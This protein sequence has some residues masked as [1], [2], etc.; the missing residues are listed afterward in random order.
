MN[1]VKESDEV[2]VVNAVFLD[3]DGVI[4][5]DFGYVGNWADFYF[6]PGALDALKMLSD[7][8]VDIF[9]VTNQSG[10][11]RG[12]YT[13]QEFNSLTKK[14]LDVMQEHGVIISS[15]YFCPHHIEGHVVK[16]ALKC[17][18]RKPL[19]GMLV[20][21]ASDFDINFSEAIMIGDKSSDMQAAE[22]AGI[23]SRYFIDPK[24]CATEASGEFSTMR[25][26]SLYDSVDFITYQNLF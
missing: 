14:M 3:R 23:S 20:K 9:I 19:P 10:I 5:Q 4:N 2:K 26:K 24:M 8:N 11:A 16:Y 25:F 18:C 6:C 12:Y 17:D 1:L 13:E 22:A 7:K 15:V 21:A